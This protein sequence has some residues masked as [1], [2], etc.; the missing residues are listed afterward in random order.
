MG[1]PLLF[2]PALVEWANLVLPLKPLPV[3]C[4]VGVFTAGLFCGWE[5]KRSFANPE[6]KESR[7]T[8]P[9][10]AEVQNGASSKSGEP[11]KPGKTGG[12]SE[13][14]DTRLG[15]FLKIVN[16]AKR[17]RAVAAIADGLSLEE[18]RKAIASLEKSHCLMR[19]DIVTRLLARWGELDP[20]GALQYAHDSK[21]LKFVPAVSTIIQSWVEHDPAAAEAYVLAMPSNAQKRSALE[22]LIQGL[23]S[24]NPKQAFKVLM[25]FPQTNSYIAVNIFG[26]W[27][28][29][30][31]VEAAEYVLQL[32]SGDN[33]KQAIRTIAQT[34]AEADVSRALAW[35]ES[36]ANTKKDADPQ[37]IGMVLQAWLQQDSTAAMQWLRTQAE[38]PQKRELFSYLCDKLTGENPN[39][40]VELAAMMPN[41]KAQDDALRK[42]TST[43]ARDDLQ[44]AL[45]WVQMQDDSHVR[46][47]ILPSVADWLVLSQPAQAMKL[48]QEVPGKTGETSAS[49]VLTTWTRHDPM[50]A[51]AWAAEQPNRTQYLSRI[52]AVWADV[53]LTKTGQWLSTFPA[54]SERDSMLAAAAEQAV[55]NK[56]ESAA[57]WIAGI[58]DEQKRIDAYKNFASRWLHLQPQAAQAWISNAPLS[59]ELKNQMLIYLPR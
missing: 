30:N 6:R 55:N 25:D 42:I 45:A 48:A 41:G 12:S 37:A 3:L 20:K 34:W 39:R 18:V 14:F 22:G 7:G 36:L 33:K 28:E 31:P 13:D 26:A 38:G 40:A 11:N 5:S 1:F 59:A 4:A 49:L 10:V 17:T 51:I 2:Q 27:A 8:L 46:E 56:P 32:P 57:Q 9:A 35:V 50:A 43:W 29:A 47:M 44:G 58:Q 52:A 19:D 16:P 23:A 15:A 54:S 21:T 53:D 24:I